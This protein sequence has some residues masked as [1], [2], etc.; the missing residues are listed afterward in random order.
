MGDSI[1][2]NLKLR[3]S[4]FV[5]GAISHQH[6]HRHHRSC[7]R[8]GSIPFVA[9]IEEMSFS[10]GPTFGSS[11][12][13]QPP[14]TRPL[15]PSLNPQTPATPTPSISQPLQ[16]KPPPRPAS[17]PLSFGGGLSHSASTPSLTQSFQTGDATQ[18]NQQSSFG[19]QPFSPAPQPPLT[20]YD[21]GGNP[22]FSKA[23][24]VP[25][26]GQQYGGLGGHGLVRSH[27]QQ[28]PPPPIGT[29]PLGERRYL[30]S[31][32][33]VLVTRLYAY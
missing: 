33:R 28:F 3:F 5:F 15:Y 23:S 32:L 16:Q 31:H 12:P 8:T 18:A 14:P 1:W 20:T 17:V 19:S 29:P 26:G 13:L 21:L 22:V 24:P 6:H 7:V 2:T 11:T 9:W 25:W 10:R 4:F 27:S 30:P